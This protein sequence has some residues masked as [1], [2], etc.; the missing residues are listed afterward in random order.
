MELDSPR[1]Y[2]I[3][4]IG[5][6]LASVLMF[7]FGLLRLLFLVPIQLVWIRRGEQAAISS[8][9]VTLLGIAAASAAS[10]MQVSAVAGGARALV[11]LDVV[12]VL[13]MLAGLFTMN[14]PRVRVQVGEG[15]R[16]LTT[17][18][19]AIATVLLGAAL[20]GPVLLWISRGATADQLIAVQVELIR[21][22]LEATGA[23]TD[24]VWALT[25]LV[26]GAILSGVL[27][28]FLLLV[29]ANWWVGMLV[30]FRTRLR[31]PAGNP[32]MERLSSYAP[33]QFVL[34][35]WFVWALIVAWAGVLGS[36]VFD[37]QGL[38]YVFWNAGFVTLALYAMQG[39]SILL[40]F[41][42]RRKLARGTRMMFAAGLVLGLLIPG[43]NIVIGLG[44]PGLGV[45][46]M[47]VD[48]HRLKGSEET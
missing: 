27:F 7:R 35:A 31:L 44:L 43:L 4:V 39:I 47:W 33:A 32:V 8:S 21:P 30:A 24:E 48:F 2:W 15:S 12:F 26:V 23:T 11:V 38:S 36:I 42:E 19:R 5:L 22:L 28:G 29:A 46:E 25:E 18:E 20:L 37:F 10:V 41:A 17:A 40:H 16:E 1:A 9:A 14:S 13:A 45:S 3:D 6:G 34:P